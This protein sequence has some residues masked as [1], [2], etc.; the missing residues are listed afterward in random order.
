MA[1]IK[2]T[3]CGQMISDKAFK[4]PKCGCPVELNERDTSKISEDVKSN[5]IVANDSKALTMIPL[6][7]KNIKTF[8]KNKNHLIFLVLSI[9][10]LALI[11]IVIYLSVSPTK[12]T[13]VV[14]LET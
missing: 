11:A 10:I 3:K 14:E 6:P 8:W 4:C 9:I 12:K 7:P 5:A 13:G 1:L 2:C